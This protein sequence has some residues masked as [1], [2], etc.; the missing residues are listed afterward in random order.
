MKKKVVRKDIMAARV[1]RDN[2][3]QLPDILALWLPSNRRLTTNRPVVLDAAWGH[4]V[5]WKR[6]DQG[7]Y[8]LVRSDLALKPG[9]RMLADFHLCPFP[10]ETFD[11]IIFD[12]PY[13]MSGTDQIERYG[14]SHGEYL[15]VHDYYDHGMVEAARVLKPGGVLIVKGQNQ[16]V[17]GSIDWADERILNIGRD[18]GLKAVDKFLMIRRNVRPQPHERQLHSRSNYSFW[19]VFKNE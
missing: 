15:R 19:W 1:C 18:L 13:K 3:E 10:A 7:I 14:V 16:V 5:F 9:V 11:G 8:N 2:G 6:V 4:G 12:P 17:S